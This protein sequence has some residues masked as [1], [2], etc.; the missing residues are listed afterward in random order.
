MSTTTI[1]TGRLLADLQRLVQSLKV[2]LLER[3]R[4]VPEVEAGLRAAHR[5][6]AGGG[7][8]AQAFEDWRD[9]Y[10][11]QVAV[12]W[13]LACVFVRYMED[14]DLIAETYLA[15][16]GDRRRQAEDAHEGYFRA[17][18]R[19]S[20][21]EYLLDVFRRVGSIPAAR[22][23]F[24]EGKTPVW[25]VGPSGD[26][27][28]RLLTFWREID[29]EVGG[30]RRPLQV[31]GGDTRFLGDLYQDLS[32]AARKKYALLQTPGFVEEFI[33][34]HTLT[35]ATDEFGLE[36]VR[37]IDPTCG[38]GHF[39]LGAF[40]RLFRLWSEREP[41]TEPAVLAQRALDAVAGVDVNPFAGA[42]A[43][44]RLVVEALHACGVARLKG[45]P[46]W[47]VG[48][49]HGDSLYHGARFDR[50]GRVVAEQRYLPAMEPDPL[51]AIEDPVGLAHIL[52]RQYHVVV[53]NPP[54]ITVKDRALNELY[55]PDSKKARLGYQT[56]MGKYALSVPFTER[57]FE[58]AQA[59]NGATGAGHVGMITANSFMKRE[60]GKRLIEEFFTRID[61]THVIDTSGAYIPGHGTPTVIL[62][63]RNRKPVGQA[64][65]AVLGIRGEPS[66]PDDA[67]RGKVWRSIVDNL[68]NGQEQNEFV[69]VTSVD[70]AVFGK[71]PWSIGGGGAADLKEQLE[72]CADQSLGEIADSIGIT[73]FTLEDEVYIIPKD[74]ARRRRIPEKHLRPMIVGDVLRDWAE[75]ECDPAIFPYGENFAPV[76]EDLSASLFKYLMNYRTCLSNSKMFG[77]KTKVESGLKWY[78]YG[79]LTSSKLRTPLSITFAFV[80]THNHFVLDRGGKVFKQSAPI[81]KLPADA[82]EDDHL[83]LLG[84]L[85]SSTAC[86]WMKQIF[87]PKGGDHVGTEGARVRRTWWDE[88]FEFAGTQME[89]FPVIDSRA[90]TLPL[91]RELDAL[92]G[93]I[94][95]L[96]PAELVKREVPTGSALEAN[97]RETDRLQARMVALQEELDWRCYELYGLMEM[98]NGLDGYDK[99]DPDPPGLQFGERAFEIALARKV[100]ADEEQTAWFERHGST[101]I[102]EIPEHWPEACRALVQRRLDAIRDDPHIAL[103]ERPEYKRRWLREPWADQ[104]QRALRGWLLDRLE[105]ERYWPKDGSP[106]LTSCAELAER[107]AHDA[108]FLQVAALYRGR[109]D[110]DVPRLVE[111]LV[112]AEAVPFLPVLRY[113]PAG[114]TTRQVWERTWDLQRREDAGEDVGPIPVPPKYTSADFLSSDIWRLRG[115]LDVPKERFVS[116]S[117]CSRDGDPTLVVGWAGWGHLR[118]ATA[119]SSYYERMKTR[120]GWTPDRL[121]P[122][123][124]GL[125]QL[126]FWLRLWHNEVDPEFDL[127]MGDYYADFV[128]DE[129]QALGYTLDRVRTWQPP[130]KAKG[131]RGRKKA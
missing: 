110:F 131:T 43:R 3:S 62:F 98:S 24:A 124:A 112:V 29:P 85:N 105:T 14:N 46:G 80:A 2:D 113:K 6:I 73:C 126:L 16:T 107:A 118:Q 119:L 92:A 90:G 100:A 66:T 70:R 129:A 104:V 34:D 26:G 127:R 120:E 42:I 91:A 115:K 37:L 65:R 39:L 99:P 83:A 18:P 10:L 52:G 72:S 47:H 96:S 38:S 60:F 23:L 109:P 61:L 54:Y 32:A 93:E 75:Y 77:N 56:C 17:H 67:A 12:A 19:D 27:A 103:I 87:F 53:G 68:D 33:L 11:E 1:D 4:E 81:I 79:R 30:L 64:V 106:E 84:L 130:A 101:P 25:A 28:A 51:Y 102:T 48:V 59:P 63:G 97:R 108:D 125:D 117:H 114:L 86:F 8:T 69:T 50:S 55:R 82:T 74:V 78:E 15:G 116:Y 21:R 22:D 123:L 89:R 128:R 57:F 94:I 95:R 13:V 44:F 58:L 121:A 49:A 41:G 40:R 111:E 31:E 122:L 45:A 88:R 7:R 76:E 5:A 35:P 36:A 9:D 71:H 20:D